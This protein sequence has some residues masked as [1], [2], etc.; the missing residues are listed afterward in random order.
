MSIIYFNEEKEEEKTKLVR[1]NTK[2]FNSQKGGGGG[3]EKEEIIKEENNKDYYFKFWIMEW[4]CCDVV[5]DIQQDVSPQEILPFLME[6]RG[7]NIFQQFTSKFSDITEFVNWLANLVTPFQMKNIWVEKE[8]LVEKEKFQIFAKLN[9]MEMIKVLSAYPNP[10]YPAIISEK[11]NIT[12][13][14]DFIYIVNQ[15]MHCGFGYILNFWPY[16][17]Y[18]NMYI[19]RGGFYTICNDNIELIHPGCFDSSRKNELIPPLSLKI[20]EEEEEEMMEVVEEEEDDDSNNEIW[21]TKNTFLTKRE[22]ENFCNYLSSVGEDYSSLY[23]PNEQVVSEIVMI[24]LYIL[25]INTNNSRYYHLWP[26]D[27]FRDYKTYFTTNNHER[28]ENLCKSFKGILF[29]ICTENHYWLIDIKC[30]DKMIYIYDSLSKEN[31]DIENFIK[32]LLSSWNIK[33]VKNTPQQDQN[34]DCGIFIMLY[35]R[36]ILCNNKQFNDTDYININMARQ[37]IYKY[38]QNFKIKAPLPHC[39]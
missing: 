14:N 38:I 34:N 20:T 18:K 8:N 39:R 16:L 26:I 12:G 7:K 9:I 13:P 30:N 33:W 24:Y 5:F 10:I 32:S 31:K 6:G 2:F 21:E 4:E 35:A 27:I 17:H 29:P 23:T 11:N 19:K 3:S 22:R 15:I 36:D 1:L 25:L 28:I 37:N